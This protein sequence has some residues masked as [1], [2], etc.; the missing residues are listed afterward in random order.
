MRIA[1]LL[2]LALLALPA[3]GG[4]VRTY[5]TPDL[6]PDVYG[7]NQDNDIGA[8]NF[9][10]WALASPGR[11]ANNPVAAMR[12]EIAVEYLAGELRANPRWIEMSQATK[13]NMLHARQE[14]RAIVGIRPDAPS[15]PV[16]NALLGAIGALQAGDR[17]AAL[18]ALSAP[19][20]LHPP[21]RTLATYAAL[22]YSRIA[23]IAT[24]QAADQAFP[25]TRFR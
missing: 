5:D 25:H 21:P 18:H 2:L 12:A 9:A 15:Q 11:L 7:I 4:P 10:A 13:S 20:F 24:A 14:L 1:S 22:P 17:A 19:V 16:V 23:N 3:C 6:P 8:I